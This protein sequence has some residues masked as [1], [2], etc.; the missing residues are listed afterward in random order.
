MK[1]CI[2]NKTPDFKQKDLKVQKLKK[3]IFKKKMYEVLCRSKNLTHRI[4]RFP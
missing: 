4:L 1:K 2:E 3:N